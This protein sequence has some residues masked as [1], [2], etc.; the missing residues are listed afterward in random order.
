V[1]KSLISILLTLTPLAFAGGQ[2]T[3]TISVT[4]TVRPG[5]KI[6]VHSASSITIGVTMYPNAQALVWTA[7]GSCGTPENPKV[8]ASSG[9]HQLSFSPDEA[10]GKNLVCLTSSDGI[11]KTSV[12]LP[13]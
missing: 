12:R 4:A 6:E 3:A 10:Q 9:I 13:R 5:A 7:T 1:H 8:I 11:L 2:K